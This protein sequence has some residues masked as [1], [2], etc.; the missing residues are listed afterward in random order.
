M[1][2]NIEINISSK[3]DEENSGFNNNYNVFKYTIKLVNHNKFT[4]KIIKRS[5]QIVD[6]NN[7]ITNIKSSCILGIEPIIKGHEAFEYESNAIITSE[8]GIMHG[9]YFIRNLETHE[10]FEVQ[11]PAFALEKDN[12]S[13]EILFH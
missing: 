8:L 10:E 2:H 9:S 13:K 4:I 12:L 11:I 7:I 3:Y 1:Q 5:W 6:S